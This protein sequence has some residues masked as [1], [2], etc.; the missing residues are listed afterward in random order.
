MCKHENA[1][2]TSPITKW[3]PDDGACGILNN[4]TKLF[5]WQLPKNTDLD[6]VREYVKSERN[7]HCTYHLEDLNRGRVKECDDIINFIDK[8][9]EE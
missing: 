1:I 2:H 6:K 8:L 9:K 3:C 5:D 4:S 7:R